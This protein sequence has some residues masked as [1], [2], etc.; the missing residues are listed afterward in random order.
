[1]KQTHQ[2]TSSYVR[3]FNTKHIT[4]H[5]LRFLQEKEIEFIND[6]EEDVLIDNIP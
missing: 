1:M 2:N 3:T 4:S 6:E 5:F